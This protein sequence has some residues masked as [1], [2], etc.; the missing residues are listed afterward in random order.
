VEA[1]LT[2]TYW[3]A[4]T[5]EAIQEGGFV[6]SE[7][8]RSLAFCG[9]KGEV[10]SGRLIPHPD[11]SL[12]TLHYER[13][14]PGECRGA[15]RSQRPRR[16]LEKLLPRL[17]P[18]E[19]ARMRGSGGGGGGFGD[20]IGDTV[21]RTAVVE[22]DLLPAELA[23]HFASQLTDAGWQ[24]DAVAAGSSST[25]QLWL[26]KGEQG[27]VIGELSTTTLGPGKVA[28]KFMVTQVAATNGR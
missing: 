6:S 9:E 19:G 7:W 21:H 22:T 8:L 11:G 28:A 4:P 10:L 1:A 27:K 13:S 5:V 12:L 17:E 25:L 23:E 20:E 3:I 2:K 15:D 18:P 14:A 26:Y 24:L 16:A